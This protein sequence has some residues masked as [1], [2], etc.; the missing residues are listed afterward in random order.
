MH[1]GFGLCVYRRRQRDTHD[2]PPSTDLLMMMTFA[3]VF[4]VDGRLMN[5]RVTASAANASLDHAPHRTILFDQHAVEVLVARRDSGGAGAAERIENTSAA[6]ADQSTKVF[7]QWHRLDARMI[8]LMVGLLR[9]AVRKQSTRPGAIAVP[10]GADVERTGPPQSYVVHHPSGADRLLRQQDRLQARL[11]CVDAIEVT[12]P[13]FSL[14]GDMA[15]R[16]W[17]N[18]RVSG[19]A[20]HDRRWLA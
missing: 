18:R 10:Q 16:V 12:A 20:P 11:Q 1:A 8:R 3:G 14:W 19:F 5:C 6:R 15:Q 13:S 2:Y 17:R 7:H 9:L 4:D